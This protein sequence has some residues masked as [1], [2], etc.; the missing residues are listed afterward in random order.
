MFSRERTRLSSPSTYFNEANHKQEAYAYALSELEIYIG[1]KHIQSEGSCYFK[2]QDLY[3][4]YR[5]CLEKMNVDAFSIHRTRLKQH[6]I[7]HIPELEPY[8]KGK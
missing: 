8:D 2:L 3:N 5:N 6:I 1:V 4:M 7:A